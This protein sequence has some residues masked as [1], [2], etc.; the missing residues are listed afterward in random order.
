MTLSIEQLASLG[1]AGLTAFRLVLE[2]L[3]REEK[4]FACRENEF[5]SAISAL[6]DPIPVFHDLPPWMTSPV[7]DIELPLIRHQDQS[8]S[9]LAFLR[10]LF[11]AKAA[12][13]RFFSPGFR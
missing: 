8:R 4:L 9:C 1:L 13:T 10:A 12:L 7:P 6:E 5:R 11:R 2:P 3:I